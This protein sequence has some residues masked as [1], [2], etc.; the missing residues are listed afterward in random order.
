MSEYTYN[1]INLNQN[2]EEKKRL[3]DIYTDLIESIT[4]IKELKKNLLKDTLTPNEYLVSLN[5][6]IGV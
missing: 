3:Y 6:L 5:S 4:K 2:T 1:S